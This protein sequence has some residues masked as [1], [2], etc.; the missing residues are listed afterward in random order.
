[1]T[2]EE[3]SQPAAEEAPVAPMPAEVPAQEALAPTEPQS[4]PQEIPEAAPEMASE[5]PPSSPEPSTPAP[6][7]SQSASVPTPA[8]ATSSALPPAAPL[9][10]KALAAKRAKADARRDGIVERA[11][12][13]KT[14][15]NNDVQ[16]HCRVSD[17]TATRDLEQLVKDGRLKRMGKQKR[18]TYE[19]A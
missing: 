12:A 5:P 16:L 8:A 17:A 15:T 2:D 10:A 3:N 9:R 7:P 4:E 13:R 19:P 1:M 6:Q 11:R 18:P 14:V